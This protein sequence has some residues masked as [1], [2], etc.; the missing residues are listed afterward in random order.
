C[1][2]S[3]QSAGLFR[4]SRGSRQCEPVHGLRHRSKRHLTRC[5]K[6]AARRAHNR[7]RHRLQHGD[8]PR[9]PPAN[10]PYLGVGDPIPGAIQSRSERHTI[11]PGSAAAV[12]SLRRPVVRRAHTQTTQGPRTPCWL[13]STFVSFADTPAIGSRKRLP[14]LVSTREGVLLFL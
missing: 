13:R 1:R 12:A 9:T 7:H 8:A 6:S 5:R 2:R 10:L 11:E 4:E 14:W 3:C